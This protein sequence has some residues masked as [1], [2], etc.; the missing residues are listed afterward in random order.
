MKIFDKGLSEN[1]CDELYNFGVSYYYGSTISKFGYPNKVLTTTNMSWPQDVIDSSSITIIYTVPT[2]LCK[3][4][5]DELVDLGI[6]DEKDKVS[7]SVYLWT[8]GAYIPPHNDGNPGDSAKAI[9][10][11][12]NKQWDIKYGGTFHYKDKA[13][14]EW[15][16]ITPKRGLLVYNDNFDWHYTTPVLGNNLRVSLQMF[17]TSSLQVKESDLHY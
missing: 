1:L 10:V 8:P 14:Q 7:A 15:K 16:S 13:L 5:S 6:I 12:L 17:L 2:D 4:I 11:Y 9:T 3:L